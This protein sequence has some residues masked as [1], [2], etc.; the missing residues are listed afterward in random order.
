MIGEAGFER[1][2]ETEFLEAP[3][4]VIGVDEGRDGGGQLGAVAVGAAMCLAAAGRSV[5][6]TVTRLP[7]DTAIQATDSGSSCCSRRM[8]AI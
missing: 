1:A 4:A 8:R 6:R 3:V 7:L 5:S 2:F